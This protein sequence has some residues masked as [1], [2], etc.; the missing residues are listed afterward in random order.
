[1]D[2]AT[3]PVADVPHAAPL[4][5]DPLLGGYAYLSAVSAPEGTADFI[6]GYDTCADFAKVY[7]TLTQKG[8]DPT[9]P[10]Y[11]ITDDKLLV[12]HDG[13]RERVCVHTSQRN[14]VLKTLHDI[15]L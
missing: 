3:P 12:F 9:C 7:R 6:S 4:E 2:L 13:V 5:S 14:F 10:Q 8:K 1:M 11:R 15:P